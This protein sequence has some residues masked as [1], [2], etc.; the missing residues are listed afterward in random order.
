M[1]IEYSSS[2]DILCTVC[3][4]MLR[5]LQNILKSRSVKIQLFPEL[6]SSFI[7]NTSQDKI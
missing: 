2:V 4:S 7:L 3:I 1:F 5:K 6:P